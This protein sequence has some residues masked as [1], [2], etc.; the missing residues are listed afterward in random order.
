MINSSQQDL[1]N[2]F[3]AKEGIYFETI[4]ENN[5]IDLGTKILYLER[6]INL[7]S[8]HFFRSLDKLYNMQ[9]P[10]NIELIR[11]LKIINDLYYN[12]IIKYDDFGIKKALNHYFSLLGPVDEEAF[13]KVIKEMMHENISVL[14]KNSKPEE[15]ITDQR[16]IREM[17]EMD[18]EENTMWRYKLDLPQEQLAPLPFTLL[19]SILKEVLTREQY[20]SLSKN[21]QAIVCKHQNEISLMMSEY[22]VTY[23]NIKSL[24]ANELSKLLQVDLD[25]LFGGMDLSAAEFFDKDPSIRN[26]LVMYLEEIDQLVNA[27]DI[28]VTDFFTFEEPVQNQLINNSEAIYTLVKEVGISVL[29]LLDLDPNL[30][31]KLIEKSFNVARLVNQARISPKNLLALESDLQDCFF[32]KAPKIVDLIKNKHIPFEKL[33]ALSTA[34]LNIVLDNSLSDAAQQILNSH[35]H[36]EPSPKRPRL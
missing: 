8:S 13:Q 20:Q 32:N 9:E 11:A 24:T 33:A 15:N 6:A 3:L 16:I 31:N 34:Q 10:D 29:E 23:E 30:R 19:S 25:I 18:I 5:N 7:D 28:S 17:A 2:S 35:D 27:A 36:H 1:L 22:N 26:K 14:Y 21:I 4:L 12:N